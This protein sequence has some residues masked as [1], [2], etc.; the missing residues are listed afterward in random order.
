MKIESHIR[1]IKESLEEIE[2]AVNIGLEQRQKTIGFHCSSASVDLLEIYLH[3]KNLIDPGFQIKHNDF[4]SEKMATNKLPFDF[5]N[6]EGI[7][8]AMVGIEKKRNILCYGKQQNTKAIE[9]YIEMFNKIKNLL[10][11]MGVRY[12]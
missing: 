6:K 12:E 2:S 9:D 11:E 7:I 1:S 8:D 3:N 10:V 4:G 5:E